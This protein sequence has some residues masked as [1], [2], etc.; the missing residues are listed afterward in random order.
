MNRKGMSGVVMLVIGAL[1]A[2]ILIANVLVPVV[3]QSRNLQTASE[4]LVRNDA[5]NAQN[6]TLEQADNNLVLDSGSLSITGLTL[7]ANYTVDY[8]TGIVTFNST[9]DNG[10]YASTYDYQAAGYLTNSTHRVVIGLTILASLL[11]I[12]V[13]IFKGFSLWD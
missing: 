10:T 2:I 7:T 5:P 3:N 4:N 8:D 11:G 1:L 13:L 6:V 9:T 12:V